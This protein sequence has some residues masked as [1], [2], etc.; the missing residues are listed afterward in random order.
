MKTCDYRDAQPR[1][2]GKERKK[3]GIFCQQP[4]SAR[5]G[6]A[7]CRQSRCFLCEP[8]RKQGASKIMQFSKQQT[9]RFLNQYQAILNCPAV[10]LVVCLFVSYLPFVCF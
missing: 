3:E 7:E 2:I 4:P 5:Y 1:L 6:T 9:H 10:S 8:Q